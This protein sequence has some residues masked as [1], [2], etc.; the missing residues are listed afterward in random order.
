M[1]LLQSS[2]S[3]TKTRQKHSKKASAAGETAG[4]ASKK[5]GEKTSTAGSNAGA[6][7][8]KTNPNTDKKKMALAKVAAAKQR[9]KSM[10]SMMR[11]QPDVILSS[12]KDW[13]REETC[14]YDHSDS[15]SQPKVSGIHFSTGGNETIPTAKKVKLVSIELLLAIATCTAI[16]YTSAY[17]LASICTSLRMH[18]VFARCQLVVCSYTLAIAMYLHLHLYRNTQ[19]TPRRTSGMKR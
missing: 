5:T 10:F 11:E 3:E 2:K 1:L 19:R 14:T 9:A 6:T 13:D 4:V 17:L 12:D 16:K 7:K 18:K 8:K 15:V